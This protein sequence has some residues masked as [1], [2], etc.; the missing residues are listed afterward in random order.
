M[1]QL[2]ALLAKYRK[3]EVA[4]IAGIVVVVNET[5]GGGTLHWLDVCCA[6]LGALGVA[7]VPNTPAPAV[8]SPVVVPP[9]TP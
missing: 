7:L 5:A 8:K 6:V 2:L 4:A 9:A 3:F 1:T